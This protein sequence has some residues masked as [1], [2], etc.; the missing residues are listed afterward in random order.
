MGVL[1]RGDTGREGGKEMNVG[2]EARARLEL[3]GQR[4][5]SPSTDINIPTATAFY[6][7]RFFI[8]HS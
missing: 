5:H 6:Y 4:S 3:E 8:T 2:E 1:G 7:H